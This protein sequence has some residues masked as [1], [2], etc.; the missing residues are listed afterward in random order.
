MRAIL[1]MLFFLFSQIAS[2]QTIK[3]YTKPTEKH[4]NI[5]GSDVFLI[6][7]DGFMLTKGI[8]G[9]MHTDESTSMIMFM[10]LP[11]P[12]QKVSGGF[13]EEMMASKGLKLYHRETLTITG[14]DALLLRFDQDAGGMLFNKVVLAYGD[15][16]NS[17]LL[18]GM[19]QEDPEMIQA[20]EKSLRSIV[21]SSENTIEPRQALDYSIDETGTGFQFIS[22][23]G[24][25]M[26]FNRD[27]LTPTQSADKAN[28]I[29]NK[30]FLEIP[31]SERKDFCIEMLEKFPKA[32]ELKNKAAIE[33]ININGL[34]GYQLV[35]E[36][37][38]E[39]E[40]KLYQAILFD[41]DYDFYFFWGRYEE[42]EGM[43]SLKEIRELLGTFELRE[44]P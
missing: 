24:T 12:F 16:K 44:A 37:P 39:P 41:K 27:G 34:E 17:V 40:K 26:L 22:V 23:V 33:K 9:F 30:S 18:T 31:V 19:C 4:V 10:E 5:P 11:G 2:T 38:G 7:P 28:I 1:P 15:P 32:Y 35:A 6:P 21:I 20:I 29:I 3:D 43:D 13:N 25:A 42:T 8:K 36:Q 14:K